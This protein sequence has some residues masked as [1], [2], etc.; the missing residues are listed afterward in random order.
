MKSWLEQSPLRSRLAAALTLDVGEQG[1]GV[2]VSGVGLHFGVAPPAL[3]Q[4]AHA[5]VEQAGGWPLVAEGAA[6]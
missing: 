3:Q 1:D 5:A 6:V 4:T 2:R